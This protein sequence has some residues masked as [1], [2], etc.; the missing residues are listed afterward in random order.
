LL[1]ASGLS[2]LADGIFQIALPL[3]ALGITREPGAFA[4]VTLVGRLPW[5]FF[6]L[7]AGALADRLDRRRT[8]VRVDV[9]RALAIAP[10]A[11]VVALGREEL[12]MLYAV[13]FALGVAETLHDT[14]AQ[15]ILP[16]VVEPERLA[17]ANSRLYAVELTAN[18]FV[19]PPI[20]GLL[21]AAALAGALSASAVGYGLAAIALTL[22]VGRFRPAR[23]AIPPSLRADIAEGVRYLARHR[24]LR[25]LAVCV[26]LSNLASTATIAVLPLYAVS[27]GPMGLSAAGYGLLLAAFAAGSLIGTFL[28]EPIEHRLGRHRTMLLA[29][30]TFPMFSLAPALTAN[31]AF[32]AAAFLVASALSIGWNV[33]T[34]SLRQRIVPDHL[35]GRVNAG[36]RLVAWGT[37][38]IGAALGGLLGQRFGI[39]TVF[40]TSAAVSAT[41]IPLVARLGDVNDD[42]HRVESGGADLG[43]VGSAGVPDAGGVRVS[44]GSCGSSSGCGGDSAVRRWPGW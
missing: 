37:M 35:L 28:V 43:A 19:G 32:V 17:R 2:N 27:P 31:V 34:V 9:A 21:A 39:T 5:L 41:C 1:T 33:I 12:W 44:I 15:S 16:N 22:L 23:A 6:A 13:A 7:P 30:T 36:Y 3:V 20:G 38:P 11:V 4:A 18:Q 40:W 26:G 25:T 29:T 10:L 42:Q 14:A 24:L 8:M